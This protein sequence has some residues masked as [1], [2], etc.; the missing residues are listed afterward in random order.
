V[1]DYWSNPGYPVFTIINIR[2]QWCNIPNKTNRLK[3]PSVKFSAL[4]LGD[5]FTSGDKLWTKLS[6]S[7]ARNHSSEE[8]ALEEN[9]FGYI[10][11]A[12]CSFEPDDMVVFA[13]VTKSTAA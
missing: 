8:L 2:N 7:T 11:S 12:V 6:H 9:G 4:W 13:A 5:R 10:G 3:P 1:L